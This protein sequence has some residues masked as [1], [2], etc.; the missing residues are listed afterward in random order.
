MLLSQCHL[1][2]VHSEPVPSS[3]SDVIEPMLTSYSEAIEDSEP[4]PFEGGSVEL[5]LLPLYPQHT[6][7][8][9]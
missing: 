1:W 7:R 5:S 6:S 3:T 8:H 2:M 4:E 9:I